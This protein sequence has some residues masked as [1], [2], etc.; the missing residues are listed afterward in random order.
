MKRAACRIQVRAE[1]LVV[2][3]SP[4]SM[5]HLCISTGLGLVLRSFPPCLPAT[6]SQSA[7]GCNVSTLLFLF[8]YLAGDGWP[9]QTTA[10]VG[11]S[12]LLLLWLVAHHSLTASI[13]LNK[14]RSFIIRDPLNIF[15][16][17][18]FQ[19]LLLTHSIGLT[20]VVRNATAHRASLII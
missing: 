2:S 6:P 9:Y 12:P 15:L 19:H 11:N 20:Q 4:N 13:G 5:N 8:L 10:S 7:A 1:T 14:D 3:F 17:S 18:F 16:D